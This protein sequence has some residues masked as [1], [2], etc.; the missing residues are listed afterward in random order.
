MNAPISNVGHTREM[1]QGMIPTLMVLQR[2]SNQEPSSGLVK[3]SA[4]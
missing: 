4:F 2:D 3:I 1:S